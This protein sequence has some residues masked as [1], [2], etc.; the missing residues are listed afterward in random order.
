MCEIERCEFEKAAES[1][2]A[3][4]ARGEGEE[5][6]IVCGA[7]RVEFIGTLAACVAHLKIDDD[8]TASAAE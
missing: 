8:K 4:A 2:G 5:K 6:G 1:V 3:G 7:G